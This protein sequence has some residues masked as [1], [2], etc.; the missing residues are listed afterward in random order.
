[1][2]QFLSYWFGIQASWNSQSH[3]LNTTSWLLSHLAIFFIHTWTSQCWSCLTFINHL[4]NTMLTNFDFCLIC[5]IPHD[6]TCCTQS[7]HRCSGINELWKHALGNSTIYLART[8][9]FTKQNL[10]DINFFPHQQEV[11]RVLLFKWAFS[12]ESLPLFQAQYLM[13]KP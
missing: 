6:C 3:V 2:G 9:K 13:S 1:M 12:A 7:E 4:F 11:E 10:R 8:P 5:F